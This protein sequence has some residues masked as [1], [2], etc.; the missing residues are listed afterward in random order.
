MAF[1][2]VTEIIIGPIRCARDVVR[3]FGFWPHVRVAAS[4]GAV[5]RNLGKRIG[6]GE[7]W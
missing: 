3:W 4:R 5:I 2:G 7:V 6:K 1:G